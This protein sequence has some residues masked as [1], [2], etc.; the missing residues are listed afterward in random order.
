MSEH[1]HPYRLGYR[2]TPQLRRIREEEVFRTADR[3]REELLTAR[4]SARSQ[5]LWHVA[6]DCP[7]PLRD[8]VIRYFLN[9]YPLPLSPVETLADLA[10]QITEDVIIH[11]IG[12]G[13]DWM[14]YGDVSLPSGWRPEEKI[15]RSFQEIH[16]PV[17]GMQLERSF[18][19]IRSVVR[20]GP[21][22]RFVWSILF[23]RE[24]NGHPDRLKPEFDPDSPKLVVKV[25]RQVL[26]G[27][28]EH[29]MVLFLLHHQLIPRAQ[30]DLAALLR[31]VEGMSEEQRQYKGLTKSWPPLRDWMQSQVS[32]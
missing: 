21:F 18:E 2:V 19:L 16:L 3:E 17:A 31:A 22:E 11:R 28:P 26:V 8:W 10:E 7:Q 27:C 30:V 5:Q 6:Q 13:R 12:N 23:S 4:R 9:H 29:E 24:W 1:D 15:G 32:P 25:E 14:A 20:N